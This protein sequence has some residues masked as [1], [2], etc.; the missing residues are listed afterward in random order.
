[1]KWIVALLLVVPLQAAWPQI[2]TGT[3]IVYN[4]TQDEFTVA[5][6]SRGIVR[7]T[8]KHD[9]N[10]CKI[11]AFGS[12]FVFSMAGL[13]RQGDRWDSHTVARKIWQEEFMRD[14]SAKSLVTVVSDKWINAMER[15]YFDNSVVPY[16]RSTM[17]PG[18]GPI[19]SSA[20][21]AATDKSGL[22]FYR[23]VTIFFDL[24]AF[25]S[26]GTVRLQEKI[27]GRLDTPE[28]WGSMGRNEIEIEFVK[29]A[30][31]RANQYMDWYGPQISTLDP[32]KLR[33]E[34][35]T[36]FVELSIL[37]HPN[38]IELGFPIDVLQLNGK[39]GVHWIS[40]KPNCPEN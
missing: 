39:T 34:L 20:V 6:D 12:N 16:M 9:D 37:L 7:G 28:Q 10:E 1:M 19:I 33:S 23:G 18:D 24:Q 40:R 27:E 4:L 25:D 2:Q 38:N 35:A 21:F 8:D 13:T 11:S 31:P 32:S 17:H 14:A 22:V 5:A 26:S 30:T 29:R 36:K 15:I 3:I